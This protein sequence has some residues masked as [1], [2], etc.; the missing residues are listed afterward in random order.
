MRGIPHIITRAALVA[1]LVTLPLAAGE[2]L[3]EKEDQLTN[4]T[5][6]PGEAARKVK[7]A[8]GDF[9]VKVDKDFEVGNRKAAVIVMHRQIIPVA[10]FETYRCRIKAKGD[11][12][13][14]ATIVLYYLDKDKKQITGAW[15]KWPTGIALTG[16]NQEH[17]VEHK[18]LGDLDAASGVVSAV[19]AYANGEVGFIQ[20]AVLVEGEGGAEL[21][22][23]SIEKIP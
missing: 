8:G 3:L 17:Q 21:S 13:Q 7:Q 22:E 23:F 12:K 14:T 19:E 5:V 20:F 15:T 4:Y 9:K 16:R 10:N 18:I 1:A 6:L 2:N 11:D